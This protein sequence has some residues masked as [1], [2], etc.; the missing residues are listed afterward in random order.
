M[1]AFWQNMRSL[2][3]QDAVGTYDSVITDSSSAALLRQEDENVAQL[4]SVLQEFSTTGR[5]TFNSVITFLTTKICVADNEDI[6]FTYIRAVLEVFVLYSI[7]TS[8][9]SWMKDSRT[10]YIGRQTE[11]MSMMRFSRPENS[12]PPDYLSK[13]YCLYLAALLKKMSRHERC[14]AE[15]IKNVVAL[16]DVIRSESLFMT[17][18]HD[19]HFHQLNAAAFLKRFKFDGHYWI[20]MAYSLAV[21]PVDYDPP[22]RYTDERI[23]DRDVNCNVG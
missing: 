20:A 19:C 17:Y 1:P 21:E 8:D 11:I 2:F 3:G 9:F 18:Q 13:E 16:T 14:R 23:E 5:E 15:I 7:V 10:A 6:L 12:C 22:P 4:Q